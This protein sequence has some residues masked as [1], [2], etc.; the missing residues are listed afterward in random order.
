MGFIVGL[1]PGTQFQ[2]HSDAVSFALSLDSL[3]HTQTVTAFAVWIWPRHRLCGDLIDRSD[4]LITSVARYAK[5][6][7]SIVEEPVLRGDDG[8]P[9]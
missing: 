3:E 1:I 4:A 9:C 6:A 8:I 2:T 5:D 7:V